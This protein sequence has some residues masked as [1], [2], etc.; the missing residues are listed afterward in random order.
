MEL[1]GQETDIELAAKG[2]VALCMLG[3]AWASMATVYWCIKL[4][5]T[6]QKEDK[7]K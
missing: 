2:I 4:M 5:L 3:I 6:Y 1:T 7:D